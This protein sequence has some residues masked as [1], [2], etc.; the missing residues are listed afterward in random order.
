[1]TRKIIVFDIETDPFKYGEKPAPFL[2]GYFDGIR[3][4]QFW[5]DD[6]IAQFVEYTRNI[7]KSIMYA[8][9]GGKF[10][11]FFLPWPPENP[12]II[13]GRIAQCDFGKHQLRDSFCILPFS[14]AK[15]EKTHIDYAKF[16][17]DN[18]E[19]NKA[20][21]MQYHRDDLRATYDLVMAFR[22]RFGN[23]LTV[24]GAAIKQLTDIHPIERKDE[25][26]D[27][28]FRPYLFGG[29]VQ[30][31]RPGETCGI[32][33]GFD[34]NSM[35]PYVMA[36]FKHPIGR[37]YTFSTDE[38]ALLHDSRPGFAY[39]DA[40]ASGCFP[41]RING[42]LEFPT[43]RHLFAITLHELRAA[44]ELGLCHIY[45]VRAGWLSDEHGSFGKFVEKFVSE[46]VAAK[47]SG[48]KIAELFAKLM[49]NSAY[50]KLAANP[51]NYF[52]Y[53]FLMTS[54]NIPD[55]WEISEDFGWMLIIKRPSPIRSSSYY[56]VATGAS[57]TGAAR[58]VLMRAIHSADTPIYCD[59][60]SLICREI[61]QPTD[62][63]E[64]G[65]WKQE[66]TADRLIV[67]ARKTYAAYFKGKAIKTAS[68]GVQLDGENFIDLLKNGEYIFSRDAPNY[69][70]DGSAR[71]TKRKI[72]FTRD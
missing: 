8:H 45:S 24:A 69:K 35:Y 19:A 17:R 23:K 49:L 54:E 43:G 33:K 38:R 21:I 46:K 58:S 3:F 64:L 10:D 67:I 61:S 44:H 62:D 51:E 31:F 36:K 39:V 32:F 52:D 26:H 71:F 18:R 56:D 7:P 47:H 48:D 57:I 42:K 30:V 12:R 9:N 34:V 16:T 37:A 15:Y 63:Y 72:T 5:G 53:K 1:M 27:A 20:E 29:R 28:I 25:N 22:D 13:N 50:G 70:K 14:L 2:I 65:A 41:I 68:K 59:T 6:C 66:F 11:F 55:G 40:E 60:D 4:V